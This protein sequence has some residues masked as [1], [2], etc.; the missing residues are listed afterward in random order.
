[1]KGTLIGPGLCRTWEVEGTSPWVL[2]HP[3]LPNYEVSRFHFIP[4]TVSFRREK[5]TQ[6]RKT[7]RRQECPTRYVGDSVGGNLLLKEFRGR[8]SRRDF[9]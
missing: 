3:S 2:I 1:M 6:K 8:P 5:F 4:G 7:R 9:E